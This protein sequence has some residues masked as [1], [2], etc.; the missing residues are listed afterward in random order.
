[1]GQESIKVGSEN[2]G[3]GRQGMR[4]RNNISNPTN[5]CLKKLK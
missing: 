1:M 4:R 2:D 3:N 5:I